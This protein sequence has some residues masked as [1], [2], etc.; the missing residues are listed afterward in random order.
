MGK[1][2]H[3]K[4]RMFI[5]KTEWATEWGGA[6]S[7]EL[8]TPFKR[9]P[10][11]CCALTFTPFEDAVCTEDGSVFDIMHIIPYIRKYGKHP[12]SGVPLKQEDLIS[13]T[14]HKNSEG[15]YHCPVLNKVFTEFT[16]IVAIKT[17]G[18]VFSYEAVKELNLKTKNWKELLTDELFKREDII[19]IQNPNTIDNK[20]LV[21]FDHVKKNLKVDDEEHMKMTSDPTYNIN[22]SGDI[23]KMLKELKTE[24]GRE[25]ALHGG[26]GNKAQSERAAALATILAA[27]E[28]IKDNPKSNSEVKSQQP[29]FSI[30]D[31]ASASVHGRSAAAAKA[32]S[33]D[34]TAARIAMHMSGDRTPVNAKMV[35]SQYTSG[36]ASRSFTSTSYDPVTKNELE[37]VKV[38]KNPKKKGYVQL[39]T[40][41]GDLN[42]ELHCDITPRAC[43]NFIT[44]CER[45]YYNGVVFHR[46]IRNFMIQGGDPTGTGKGGESIWGKPFKDEV[47]SK[48]LHY[49][50][51]VVSMANSGPHS[52]G[53][54]FFILYKSANHL[55]FKHTVFGGVVG[56]LTTLSVMEKVPVDDDDRPLEEIKITSVSIF[57]NPY[58][59][60]DEE[61]EEEKKNEPVEDEENEKIGSWYSNPGTGAEAEASGSVGVGKYLKAR[62]TKVDSTPAP[63]GDIVVSKKRKLGLSTTQELKDFSAW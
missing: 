60:P 29:A 7:K 45:G 22:V 19:T 23:K 10:F 17:T 48:L 2:Q 49:G 53:S 3:S 63:D 47:N 50:R 39:H 33:S 40:T 32:A 1:K 62:T 5:T 6:K 57:V 35:K 44:L 54:Q 24:K 12:V 13:L 8:R 46:N 26:G 38:E 34:K 25:L 30:V 15:E 55:N 21:D 52:N 42:I 59:E 27:R 37:Y 4:D 14:F 31:A 56:G 41:H 20:A 28:R 11:Y 51:G 43:E 9:L 16:H 61:E 36:A 18:N 58:S